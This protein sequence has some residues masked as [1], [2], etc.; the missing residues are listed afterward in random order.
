M[1]V[2]RGSARQYQSYS[3]H[4]VKVIGFQMISSESDGFGR[5]KE[6]MQQSKQDKTDTNHY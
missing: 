1:I 6:R 2:G 5:A 4:S 3:P